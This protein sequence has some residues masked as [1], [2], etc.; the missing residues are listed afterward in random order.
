MK[1]Y[2]AIVHR[3]CPILA[4][5]ADNFSDKYTMVEA[6]TASLANALVGFKVKLVV[7]LDGCPPEYERL[8]NETF[9]SREHETVD[10][11]CISTP[12]IGNNA[13]YAKQLEIL[14]AVASEARY[15]YFS[16]D[17]YI[18]K[19]DAF[20]A[21]MDFL[22]Q[23]GVDFVTPLDHPD[24]YQ[25]ER[26]NHMAS[27]V[28][29]SKWCHWKEVSSTCCTFMLKSDTMPMAKKSLSYYANGGSDFIMGL[30]LTKKGVF[31]PS[32]VIGG[33]IKYVFGRQRNWMCGIPLL[34]WLKLGPRLIYAHRFRLWSPLPTLAVHLCTPSRPPF[35]E[36]IL[37]KCIKS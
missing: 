3:V 11:S 14:S 8:F 33:A 2:L 10:F 34:A 36:L 13:T 24:G 21:M 31:S 23:D 12:S 20:V 37:G 17:D 19:D 35:A 28:R 6:T 22:N 9:G 15:L 4:K 16:E 30:L 5:T 27:V 7:I 26:E 32:V 1:Y 25:R 29:A 18:Y